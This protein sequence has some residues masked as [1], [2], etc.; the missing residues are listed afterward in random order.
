MLFRFEKKRRKWEAKGI[1]FTLR[2]ENDF[3]MEL[4]NLGVCSNTFEA[5][6]GALDDGNVYHPRNLLSLR[7]LVF[8]RTDGRG[9]HLVMGDG[10]FSVA[11]QE[12][13]QEHLL[14]R[15]YLCQFICALGLLREGGNFVCKL[16][17]IFSPVSVSL[18]YL[19]YRCFD[20]MAIVKPN[21]SRPANSE[22]FVICKYLRPDVSVV[23]DFLFAVNCRLDQLNGKYLQKLIPTPLL[24][25]D[26]R[27]CDYI[28]SVNTKL[29]R[30]QIHFLCKMKAFALDSTLYESKKGDL[31][32]RCL[33]IWQVPNRNEPS[34]TVDLALAR[35]LKKDH[36]VLYYPAKSLTV[37]QLKQIKF[38]WNY[39]FTTLGEDREGKCQRGFF[40]V[41][42]SQQLQFFNDGQWKPLLNYTVNSAPMSIFYGELNSELKGEANGQKKSSA[43]H[44]LDA[45]FVGEIQVWHRPLD[46]RLAM[47]EKL[48]RVWIGPN[49]GGSN[50]PATRSSNVLPVRLKKYFNLAQVEQF[51]STLE[52]RECKG[53]RKERL[54]QQMETEL[55]SI[56]CGLHICNTLRPPWAC[57]FSQ[58]GGKLYY[59]NYKKKTDSIYKCPP[60]ARSDFVDDFSTR[61]EWT[62]QDPSELLCSPE[63]CAE[64]PVGGQSSPD[65]KVSRSVLSRHIDRILSTR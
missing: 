28:R 63:E 18:I 23:K 22:R 19:L 38:P 45:L 56:V 15:L 48:F 16:F 35:L 3:K 59:F 33:E 17:D 61:V 65:S 12:L 29:G 26:K 41:D 30:R 39:R 36:A 6:Y 51:Y 49:G 7:D 37:E 21:T 25:K 60:E 20:S 47:I 1:G 58:S 4:F 14:K 5:F 13:D 50:F 11:G 31:R 43:L 55:F 8:S 24:Q 2:N 10:G 32:R 52:M 64:E 54:C 42:K 27:F 34:L 57:R 53:K 40:F 9:A 44:L 46:E 62:W